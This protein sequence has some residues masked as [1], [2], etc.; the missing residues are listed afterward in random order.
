V[1]ATNAIAQRDFRFR[2]HNSVTFRTQRDA[3]KN[4]KGNS[5]FEFPFYFQKRIQCGCEQIFYEA[6]Q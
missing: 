5:A 6:R 2:F 3:A 1:R 4:K